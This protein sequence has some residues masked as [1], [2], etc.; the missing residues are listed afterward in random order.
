[1]ERFQI[2]AAAMQHFNKKT[3]ERL[4]RAPVR[5]QP[6]Y[7]QLQGDSGFVEA[8]ASFSNAV[9]MFRFLG[10]HRASDI[11]TLLWNVC[12]AEGNHVRVL[13]GARMCTKEGEAPRLNMFVAHSCSAVAPL[14]RTEIWPLRTVLQEKKMTGNCASRTAMQHGMV[15]TTASPANQV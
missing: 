10:V 3:H 4:K 13:G 2:F 7:E 12:G 14:P 8:R 15:R 9:D 1:M 6:E 5:F 11:K